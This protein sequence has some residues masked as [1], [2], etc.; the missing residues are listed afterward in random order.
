MLINLELSLRLNFTDVS[1]IAR[2]VPKRL[3]KLVNYSNNAGM[4]I[5]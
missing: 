3:R 2:K 5:N 1:T 4:T